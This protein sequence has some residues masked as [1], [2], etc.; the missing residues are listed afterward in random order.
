MP[1]DTGPYL[2]AALF[3]DSTIE[4]KDGVLSLIRVVDRLIITAAGHDAPLEMPPQDV[5]LNLAIMLVSGRARGTSTLALSVEPPNGTPKQFWT[6]TVLFEGE[7]RGA[8]IVAQITYRFEM[9]GLYWFHV[10]LDDEPL[11]SVPYR[12]IY[13]RIA[14]GMQPQL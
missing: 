13:Q 4:G 10:R 14:P 7:D 8:N 5:P 1:S 9:Q 6:N 11:T 12:V 2:K 3:C